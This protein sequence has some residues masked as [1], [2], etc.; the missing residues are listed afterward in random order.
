MIMNIIP[1]TI[2]VILGLL[3]T[4]ASLISPQ[5]IEGKIGPLLAAAVILFLMALWARRSDHH[6]WQSS[7]VMVL[8]V[9]LVVVAL[10]QLGGYPQLTFWGAF[11]V[12]N[13]SAVLALWAAI[14]HPERSGSK[15]QAKA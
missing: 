9:L 3:L 1:N 2:S 14:Y 15:A 8:A 11:W 12:G 7:T 5:L 13:I 4:Y 6:H 10:L